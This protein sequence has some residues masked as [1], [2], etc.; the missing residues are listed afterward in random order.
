MY[1]KAFTLLALLGAVQS[2]MHLDFPPTLLGDNNPHTPQGGADPK[3]NYP[4][5]CCGQTN[6]DPCKG[7]LGLLDQPEGRPVATWKAGQAA[8]FTL[9]GNVISNTNIENP[10]GGTHAGMQTSYN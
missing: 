5:G 2:H 8:N 4:Y 1:S 7:H 10:R 3:L 6:V 9:S